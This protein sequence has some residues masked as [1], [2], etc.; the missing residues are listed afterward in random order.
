MRFI[1]HTPLE[2]FLRAYVRQHRR[3]RENEAA[4][5]KALARIGEAIRP[6]CC[7][8][9]TA[10]V[11]LHTPKETAFTLGVTALIAVSKRSSQSLQRSQK[12]LKDYINGACCAD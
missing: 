4:L 3:H 9:P 2:M 7:D 10:T 5:N 11:N 12:M 8:N 6:G 1:N